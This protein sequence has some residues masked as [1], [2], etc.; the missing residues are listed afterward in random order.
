MF[1]EV[2]VPLDGTPVAEAA[3]EPAAAIARSFRA[4]ITLLRAV[5]GPDRALQTVAMLETSPGLGRTVDP[6]TIDAVTDAAEEAEPRARVYL[7]AL[8]R[9]L[10]GLD[11]R[12]RTYDEEAEEAILAAADNRPDALIVMASSGKGGL[13]RLLFGSVSDAVQRKS[14]TPVLL[15]P[16]AAPA[17][18]S[19]EMEQMDIKIGDAVQ[20]IDGQ[21][22]EV[23]RLIVDERSGQATDLVVKHGF[24]F[25]GERILPLGMVRRADGNTVYV[26]MDEEQFKDLNGFAEK[27]RDGD[28]DYVGPPSQDLDGTFRGNAAFDQ[29][30][31]IGPLGGIGGAAKPLGY[32]GGEQLS[33]DLTQRPAIA[34]GMSVLDRYGEKVGTVGELAIRPDDGAPTHVTLRRGLLFKHDTP[35]PSEWIDSVGTDGLVLSVTK[36]EVDQL[37]DRASE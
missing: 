24:I 20:G 5:E 8:A 17:N 3:L 9:Q 36:A 16:A 1:R 26:D 11:V 18:T 10:D 7:T 31:A 34:T 19:P 37:E 29:A 27:V 28:P 2:I 6:V 15:V 35:L 4:P 25:G 33:P 12:I 23:S 21:L 22:G 13:E 32:P 14:R 30:W